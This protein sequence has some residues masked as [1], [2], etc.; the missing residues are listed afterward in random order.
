[1]SHS[2]H[3]P[4]L[5]FLETEGGQTSAVPT[6]PALLIS[7]GV[8]FPINMREGPCYCDGCSEKYIALEHGIAA[9]CALAAPERW[10]SDS[11]YGATAERWLVTR[12]WAHWR[13]TWWDL[14]NEIAGEAE[15]MRATDLS[16]TFTVTKQISLA[17]DERGQVSWL[18]TELQ[19][20]GAG[21]RWL[22]HVDLGASSAYVTLERVIVDDRIVAVAGAEV[23]GPHPV[24]RFVAVALH[25][26][27][28]A[29]GWTWGPQQVNVTLSLVVA[30]EPS[31]FTWRRRT[32]GDACTCDS[33]HVHMRGACGAWN[34]AIT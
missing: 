8:A 5:W 16:F 33:D 20:S 7:A 15:P 26:N 23:V 28:F 24:H 9:L 34:A 2:P 22:A 17:D 29:R 31:P 4:T 32:W 13:R 27:T 25:N 10:T 3:D 18:V 21:R 12:W 30:V 11:K 1:M 6:N 19:Q 14:G